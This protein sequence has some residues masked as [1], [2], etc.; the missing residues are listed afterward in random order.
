MV[1]FRYLI[2]S[3][4]LGSTIALG[5]TSAFA[6][7]GSRS[8]AQAADLIE[9]AEAAMEKGQF[10]V[11]VQSFGRALR[12]DDLDEQLV[13]KTLYQRGVASEK[14]GQPAQAIA[15]IT[16]ALYLPG[17]SNA[18]RAQAYLS[19]GRA[20]EAVGMGDQ[21][22]SDIARAK[23][24]GADEMQV[25]RA[26]QPAPPTA[27]S[28]PAFETVSRSSSGR[29]AVPTFQTSSERAPPPVPSFQTSSSATRPE[30]QRQ[31]AAAFDTQTRASSQKEEI[32]RFRTTIVPQDGQASAAEQPD[33]ESGGRVSRFVGNLWSR[34]SGDD[35]ETSAPVPPAQTAAPQWQQET[36]VA[37][38]P[39]PPAP[40]WN[41]QV[42]SPSQTAAPAAPVSRAAP[43]A[44]GGSGYRIQLAALKTDGEAQQTWKHL[45]SKHGNL[46]GGRQPN[47]VKTELGGLGT[48]YR[49]QLGPFADKASSQQLCKDF[50]AGGLD[51]FLL[52]P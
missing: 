20:Y 32:P 41:A 30:P 18:D 27:Q 28:G 39:A 40:S 16:G 50:K 48:F 11:A 23:S 25:A 15:D 8:E 33:K 7:I 46:L 2:A 44:A 47:I 37:R 17:L 6:Q 31:Q 52:A 21:A 29:A 9:K 5:A 36:S 42:S 43:V 38:A 24:G 3:I 19:R 12:A 51:C 13:A 10:D 35:K 26:S 1:T 14:A 45:Q 4:L 34:A 22:R 49:L